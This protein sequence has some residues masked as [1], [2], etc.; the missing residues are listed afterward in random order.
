M[1]PASVGDGTGRG[2]EDVKQ[3]CPGSK[4]EQLG[5]SRDYKV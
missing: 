4:A 3:G 1:N 5:L 2:R